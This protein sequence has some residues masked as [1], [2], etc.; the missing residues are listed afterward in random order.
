MSDLPKRPT[1]A[2][3]RGR[4]VVVW[5]VANMVL[6]CG[7]PWFRAMIEG[8]IKYGLQAAAE[9]AKPDLMID[10]SPREKAQA[11][12]DDPDGYFARV[13]AERWEQSGGQR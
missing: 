3:G 6:R 7:S 4:D 10:R 5:W 12:L 2:L 13:W 11:I 1:S 8:A 9:D